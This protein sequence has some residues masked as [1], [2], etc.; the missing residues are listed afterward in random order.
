[1]A[2]ED[3]HSRRAWDLITSHRDGIYSG[4]EDMD[5]YLN[6][7]ADI[8]EL[9]DGWRAV[10]AHQPSDVLEQHSGSESEAENLEAV[11]TAYAREQVDSATN[12]RS[13]IYAQH[14]SVNYHMNSDYASCQQGKHV[15]VVDT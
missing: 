6:N 13:G 8:G 15:G 3:H 10:L 11:G 7:G 5:E 14:D 9:I 2:N 12:A 1:M 4:N